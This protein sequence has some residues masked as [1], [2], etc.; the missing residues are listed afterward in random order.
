MDVPKTAFQTHQ[1]HYEFL[2][3]PFGLTNAPATFQ[4]IMNDIF[5]PYPRKFVLVFFDDILIC[6]SDMDSH[7][8]HLRT[9]LSILRFHK[10]HAKLSKCMFVQMNVEYLGHV[11]SSQGVEMDK[12]KVECM[13]N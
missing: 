6:N 13:L 5:Q 4:S 2:V 11:I 12:A 9:V 3:M 7:V 1:E 10:L 8:Q